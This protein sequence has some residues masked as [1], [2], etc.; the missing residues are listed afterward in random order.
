MI[1]D[2]YYMTRVCGIQIVNSRNEIKGL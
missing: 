2:K 1:T